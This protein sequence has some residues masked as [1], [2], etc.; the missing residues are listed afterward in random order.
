MAIWRAL[1]RALTAWRRDPGR[2]RS[3]APKV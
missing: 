3:S 1:M 2:F